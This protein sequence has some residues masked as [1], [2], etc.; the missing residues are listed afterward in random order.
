[1]MLRIVI[2][3]ILSIV[4][5]ATLAQPFRV[6][7]ILSQTGA[8]SQQGTAQLAVTQGIANLLRRAQGNP[9]LEIIFMDDASTSQGA[10]RAA[11]SLVESD[12]VH[13]IVCCTT[14]A[15]TQGITS[16]VESQGV[17]TLTLTE[18]DLEAAP[19]WLFQIPPDTRRVLQSIVIDRNRREQPRIGVMTLDNSF[20]DA[21]MDTLSTLFVPEAG[22]L[23]VAEERYRPDA[24]V[25]TPEALLVATR[26][27]DSVIVWGLQSDTD[28]ALRALRARGFEGDV[29]LNP[30]LLDS[31]RSGVAGTRFD[32]ALFV[33]S[34][35][36][37]SQL[38]TRD[39][40][41]FETVSQLASLLLRLAR[42][43]LPLEAAYAYDALILLSNASELA[44]TYGVPLTSTA[45]ARTLLRDALISANPVI[46]AAATYNF[47]ERERVG[48][49]PASLLLAR[50]ERGRLNPLP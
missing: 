29:I 45:T 24:T 16:Y 2:S 46:G 30:D 31:S 47:S 8:A 33:V 7:V 19:N 28:V 10:L 21:L 12:G 25:L 36:Q 35:V 17:L 39:N 9:V 43:E 44:L 37:V 18:A 23:L 6:G 27:P 1:M 20:G 13:A 48:V 26:I 4:A 32:G 11:Q 50:L 49:V 38:L 3:L 41:H 22:M 5:S 15:A 34:P 42:Q 14:Q 40:P